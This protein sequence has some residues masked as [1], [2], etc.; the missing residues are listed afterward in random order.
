MA[1]V[2][3][4]DRQQVVWL[5]AQSALQYLRLLR[6]TARIAEESHASQDHV[7]SSDPATIIYVRQSTLR[8][9]LENTESTERQYA[10][11]D[12]AAEYGWPAAQIVV[13][14]EDQGRSAASATGRTGF[15]QLVSALGLGQVGL[16]LA[17]EISPLPVPKA[18]GTGFWSRPRFST[19]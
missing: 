2:L 6:G 3:L 7:R 12:K 11:V 13:I 8:Q 1:V 10:L 18:T 19:P 5:L 9:V 4:T 17:L 15:Q 16:V 14:D